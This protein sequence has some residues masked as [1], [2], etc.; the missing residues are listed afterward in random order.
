MRNRARRDSFVSHFPHGTVAETEMQ[1]SFALYTNAIS[2]NREN[3]RAIPPWMM[4]I[5][6]M[7]RRD[8]GRRD[9]SVSLRARPHNFVSVNGGRCRRELKRWRR[10]FGWMRMITLF[11]TAFVAGNWYSNVELLFPSCMTSIRETHSRYL[12]SHRACSLRQIYNYLSSDRRTNR[13]S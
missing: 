1:Q 4:E 5:N 13:E 7:T 2:S 12:L 10:T 6:S 9:H 3:P 11:T 8:P